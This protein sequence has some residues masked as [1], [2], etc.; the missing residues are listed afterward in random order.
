M[1]CSKRQRGSCGGCGRKGCVFTEP[2]ADCEGVEPFPTGSELTIGG[3]RRP[4]ETWPERDVRVRADY[5]ARFPG[6]DAISRRGT[7]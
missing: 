5:L 6:G 3:E 7:L 2:S 4:E 1:R